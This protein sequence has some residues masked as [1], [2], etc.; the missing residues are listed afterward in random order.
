MPNNQRKFRKVQD[1]WYEELKREGFE[2]IENTQREDRPLKKWHFSLFNSKSDRE[3]RHDGRVALQY[4]TTTEFYQ[5][6]SDLLLTYQF[7]SRVEK[8]IWELFCDGNTEREI[9]ALV[10]EYK[11]S[12]IHLIISRIKMSIKDGN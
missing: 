5:Q 1:H 10:K 2:D 4:R 6:A 12:S 3:P 8:R 7:A 11:K 9:A